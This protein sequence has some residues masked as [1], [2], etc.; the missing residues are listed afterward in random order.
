MHVCY[1]TFHFCYCRRH[2]NDP[3]PPTPLQLK[4]KKEKEKKKK[5]KIKN[6]RED[7]RVYNDH[8][9]YRDHVIDHV[10]V[11]A[12]H[13]AADGLLSVYEDTSLPY[14]KDDAL[15]DMGK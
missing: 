4:D 7:K 11:G 3:L 8:S 2:S 13:M 9:F 15:P 14:N 12:A 1:W 10:T 5:E 6:E